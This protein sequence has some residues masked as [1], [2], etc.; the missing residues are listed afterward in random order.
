MGVVSALLRFA[1]F[2]FINQ[3]WLDNPLSQGLSLIA[4]GTLIYCLVRFTKK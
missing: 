3:A 4:Y 2:D 1:G